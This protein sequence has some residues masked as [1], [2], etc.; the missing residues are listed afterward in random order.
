MKGNDS[1]LEKVRN[2]RYPAQTIMDAD[3]TDDIALLADTPALAE[4]LLEQATGGI[5]LDV[6]GDKTEY[7]CFNQIIYVCSLKVYFKDVKFELYLSLFT[8][9]L[10][11]SFVVLFSY[12][13]YLSFY[14]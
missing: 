14:I 5:G 10:F 1:T 12:N 13:Q 11:F 3:Y 4:S 7:K 8:Y 6:N 2:R 9:F